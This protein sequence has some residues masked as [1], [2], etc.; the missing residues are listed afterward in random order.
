M[1]ENNVDCVWKES[2]C[3]CLERKCVVVMFVKREGYI[4]CLQGGWRRVVLEVERG[5]G[6]ARES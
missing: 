6:R 1:L 3:L 2:G 4:L 5:R